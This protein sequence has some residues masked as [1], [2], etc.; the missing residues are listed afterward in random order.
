MERVIEGLSEPRNEMK[1][2]E[3]H[4]TFWER[5]FPDKTAEAKAQ[6]GDELGVFWKGKKASWLGRSECKREGLGGKG[7]EVARS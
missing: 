5:M 1:H 2:G 3:S 4:M 7:G 6:G